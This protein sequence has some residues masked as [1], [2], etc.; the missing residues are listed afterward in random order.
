MFLIAVHPQVYQ[1]SSSSPALSLFALFSSRPVAPAAAAAVISSFRLIQ[2]MATATSLP[3]EQQQLG[4]LT[5]RDAAALDVELMSS[6]GFSLGQLM[7]LAGLS[8]AEAVYDVV[9]T[10]SST[11]E[12]DNGE[13][14]DGIITTTTTEDICM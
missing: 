13:A 3:M 5:A 10:V 12:N 9:N 14:D 11:E 8:V 6:P 7:E 1:S 4:Y 2:R